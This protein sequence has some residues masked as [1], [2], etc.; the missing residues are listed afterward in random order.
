VGIRKIREVKA[1]ARRAD[2][3]QGAENGFIRKGGVGPKRDNELGVAC[4][5]LGEEGGELVEADFFGAEKGGAVFGE[6][7]G[8]NGFRVGQG[9]G[10]AGGGFGEIDGE[11]LFHEGGGDHEDDE[12]NKNEIEKW[13]D[14]EFGQSES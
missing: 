1:S 9:G 11:L 6:G 10:D 7:E 3:L 5:S 14:V 12:E 4:F 13:G 8:E 2:S